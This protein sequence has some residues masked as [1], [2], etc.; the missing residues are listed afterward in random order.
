MS[1]QQVSCTGHGASKGRVIILLTRCRASRFW[2]VVYVWD[3]DQQRRPA[4]EPE[5]KRAKG[6]YPPQLLLTHAGHRASVQTAS[7]FAEKSH[8]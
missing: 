5:A 8:H 3:L 1:L 6:A 2:Q 4:G 7:S